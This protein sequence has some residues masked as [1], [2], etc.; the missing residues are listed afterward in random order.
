[1]DF[2]QYIDH[3]MPLF[4][5]GA[6]VV[7]P[8]WLGYR[9][10]K[11]KDLNKEQFEQLTADIQKVHQVGEQNQAKLEAVQEKMAT[12]DEA[13]LTILGYRLERNIKF[14]LRR[15]FITHE[16]YNTISRMFHAYKDLG[17]NGY[18]ERLFHEFL[19]LPIKED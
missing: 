18:V 13:H 16:D 10:N 15:G 11:A 1:M 9:I 5:A 19:D 14:A 3:L 7:F 12:H 6:T 2:I 17:G 8:S 4:T